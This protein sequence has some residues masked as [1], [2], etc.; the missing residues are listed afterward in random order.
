MKTMP[1]LLTCLLLGLG[2][3]AHATTPSGTGALPLTDVKGGAVLDPVILGDLVHVPSGRIV[4]TWDYSNPAA[5]VLLASTGETPAYGVIRGLTHW[6]DYLYASWQAADDTGGVA[7]YSLRDPRR[8]ELVNQFSDYASGLKV[9]W[10]LAA[11]NGYLYVFDAESGIQFGDLGPDPLHPTLTGLMYTQIPFDRTTVIGDR[12]YIS[13]STF[14][15]VPVRV[16]WVLDVANPSAPELLPESCGNGDSTELFRHRPQLPLMAAFGEKLSLFDLGSTS[17]GQ[18]LVSMDINPATD[19]FIAGQH[20]YSLGFSGIDIHDISNPA[21]P[22]TVGHATI[23]TLGADSVT[24]VPGGALVLTSTDRFTGVDVSDPLQPTV[25]ATATPPGGAVAGDIAL[26]GGKAVILQENYGLGIAEPDTLAPLAR[27]DAD[28]PEMLYNRAFEQ[29]AVDAGRAYLAG[30]GYGLIV[31]DLSNPLQPVEL[32]RLPYSTSS[33]VAASGD[34]V[35]IGT[36]TNGG[37]LQVVDV[38]DPANPTLRGQSTLPHAI[39]RL[40]AH[41]NFVYVA[42]EFSGIHVFDVSNPDAPVR[43]ALW[44]TGC[45]NA[46]GYFAR[47]IELSADGRM[48]AVACHSGL[49]LLD[50]SQPTNPVRIGRHELDYWNNSPTV[51]M[52]GNRA[53]YGDE[54]GVKEYDISTPAMPVLLGETSVSGLSPRRLRALG[55]GHLFAFF[56]QA[57]VHVFGSSPSDAH[58]FSDGFEGEATQEN[59][60]HYDD[61]REGF[62]GT[63]HHYRGVTYHSVNGIG[64]VFPDGD[65]FTPQDVGDMLVIED[66]A[67]LYENFPSF[68]SAPNALTFGTSYIDGPNLSLGALVRASFDLDEPAREASFEMVYYENGPWGGIVLEL[69]AWRHG[70]LVDSAQLTIASGGDR[71]NLTTATLSVNAEQIDSLTL[72]A[73]YDGSP[74]APRVMIDNLKLV[75]AR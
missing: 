34:F 8:P 30:W 73:T 36:V 68:G 18:A 33:A 16:C 5:P 41:G 57:G 39:N 64:G 17:P 54:R 60:S 44:N 28:L 70:A 3:Q 2:S 40:Q 42:D 62:L 22:V 29:F 37:T 19:G 56:Y 32:G 66:A 7:V 27:F 59:I 75:P 23:P 51:T 35:Y 21:A 24:Q 50:L 1:I 13:G 25:V 9:Q 74:T 12:I 58:I 72:R 63:S 4:S 48:A 65:T 10:S 49:H 31:V 38:S 46:L 6:G 20:V 55:E 14:D 69:Q 52:Q 67:L 47:D 71:D 15:S 43:V 11:A 53:W 45:S 26:V 61:L